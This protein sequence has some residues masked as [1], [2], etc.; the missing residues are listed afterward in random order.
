ME[1]VIVGLTI[2]ALGSNE[3]GNA[4]LGRWWFCDQIEGRRWGMSASRRYRDAI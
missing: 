1:P 4:S 2:R 3:M